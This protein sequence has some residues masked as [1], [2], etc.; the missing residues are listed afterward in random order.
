MVSLKE[1]KKLIEERPRKFSA[2]EVDYR[3]SEDMRRCGRCL[4]YYERLR[5]GFGVCEIFRPADD[6]AV[7][8]EYTCDLMT[9]DGEKF[10]LYPGSR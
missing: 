10:P 3:D 5:D 6:S 2:E 8:P 4:H 9:V 7:D 1:Y